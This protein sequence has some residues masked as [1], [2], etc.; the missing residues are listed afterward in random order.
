M[1]P[2]ISFGD[3][4]HTERQTQRRPDENKHFAVVPVFEPNDD[5]L[6]VYVDIDALRDMETHALSNTHV[7]LGGV[8]LGGQYEDADGRPF[9]VVTDSLRAQH[10][11]S[12][13]GSFKFTHDTW[14]Q[15]TR[16]RDEFPE[17]LQ[18]VGWYHTHPDWGV[19]LSGMDMFI[20]DN[21]FNK[22]LDVALVIDPCRDDR[23]FF[24]WTGNPSQRKRRTGGFYLIGSR[25]RADELEY[26]AVQLEG[27]EAMAREPRMGGY[28]GSYPAPVVNI[29]ERGN[30]WQAPAIMAM[31]TIQFCVLALLAWK[32]LAPVSD[33]EALAAR[34]EKLD[35]IEQRL[36]DMAAIKYEQ[37]RLDAQRKV[38]DE[39]VGQVNVAPEGLVTALQ[40]ARN[41][42]Q[43]LAQSIVESRSHARVLDAALKTEQT[44]RK[45]E[46]AD[47][48]VANA[49]LKSDI[50]RYKKD[51]LALSEKLADVEERLEKY[52][53]QEKKD[54]K[55]AKAEP[56]ADETPWTRYA[57]Y[58]TV[59]AVVVV[60]GI[61]ALIF[62]Y[63][64]E[65]EEM[66]SEEPPPQ[67]NKLEEPPE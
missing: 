18:M 62:M 32:L 37:A 34:D 56:G 63:R 24:Q 28:P 67:T 55:T 15:I 48:Q 16:E 52:E 64:R 8:L 12:T 45:R 19:F 65:D 5:D 3:V 29:A 6:R 4:Q 51:H 49:T 36:D 44:Q 40:N 47:L 14:S 33:A 61:G 2:E 54:E 57:L 11:E 13:K 10:Y 41:T 7:E 26:F 59:A 39:V 42:N 50:D 27:T 1:D 9:V 35:A 30:A 21:F 25:F 58:G 53:P 31:M 38:L 60:L 43:D 23:A 22:P 66:F 20:C 46:K 17:E